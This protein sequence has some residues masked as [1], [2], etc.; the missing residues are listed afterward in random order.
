MSILQGLTLRVSS[1]VGGLILAATLSFGQQL[2]ISG[3]VRDASGLVPDATVTLRAGGAQPRTANTDSMGQ[4]KFDGLPPTYYEL[5]FAKSGFETVT[6][7]LA[8]GSDAATLDVVLAVGRVTTDLTVTDVGGKATASRLDIPDIDLP[9]QV[10]SIPRQ[11]LDEQG[12]ND[13]ATALRNGSGIQA[14]RFYGVYE[15][16]T[17][18]GFNASDVLLVDGMR[19][20]AVLNRFATQLNNVESIE[21]LKGPSSVLYG[22]DA[23]SGVINII[24]KK[25]QGQ[26]AYDILYKGGRFNSHQVAGGATGPIFG[27]NSWLYRANVSQDYTDG[28]RGAGANRFNA[29]P[30]LTWLM[31]ERS[32]VTV[33]QSFTRDNYKAMAACRSSGRMRPASIPA[34]GSAH[35]KISP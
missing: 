35:R 11:L 13:M 22:G 30:S 26:R 8:L 27:S 34:A 12:V 21:V 20:E 6:R 31:S 15:Q 28:W 16:F 14:Q 32:R 3:I 4:Y 18:R 9:V 33:H 10:S 17:I 5:S 7:N 2:S 1:V 23:V 29:S 19:T 24:R 25:P